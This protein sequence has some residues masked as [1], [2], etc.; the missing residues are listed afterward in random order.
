MTEAT[1]KPRQQKAAEPTTTVKARAGAVRA[2]MWAPKA[3]Q[4]MA[5]STTV[6]ATATTTA[7]SA[8]PAMRAAAGTG[9]ARRRLSTPDS[10]WAVTEMTRLTKAAAM[11]PRVMIPGT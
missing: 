9:V 8:R 11:M 7:V 6:V 2:G 1:A 5:T 3:A 10:R 4:P